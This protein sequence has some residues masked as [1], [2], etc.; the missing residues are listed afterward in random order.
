MINNYLNYIEIID[1]K[2]IAYALISPMND[3]N[4]YLP[5]KCKIIDLDITDKK[6][7]YIIQILKFYDKFE[8]IQEYFI[9]KNWTYAR[10]SSKKDNKIEERKSPNKLKHYM[11]LNCLDD[12]Y[13]IL[14]GDDKTEIISFDDMSE[15]RE[16]QDYKERHYLSIDPVCVFKNKEHM[17]GVFNDLNEFAIIQKLRDLR[18]YL[19]RDNY[20]K[21]LKI[22][23]KEIVNQHYLNIFGENKKEILKT[24]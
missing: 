12:I 15:N 18:I 3:P 13:L 7:K 8:D 24:I 17:F 16:F 19:T 14:N 22:E 9:N 10:R 2:E 11:D 20:N 23:N 6:S 1:T 4:L 21:N 5:I